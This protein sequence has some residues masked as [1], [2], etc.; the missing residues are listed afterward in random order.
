MLISHFGPF[1]GF[2]ALE[3]ISVTKVKVCTASLNSDFYGSNVL[4]CCSFVDVFLSNMIL[5]QVLLFTRFNAG[6]SEQMKNVRV[7]FH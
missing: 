2:G 7:N 1:K 3:T 6:I 5:H 4:L